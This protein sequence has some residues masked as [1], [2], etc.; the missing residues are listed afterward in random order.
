MPRA[1]IHQRLNHANARAQQAP[2]SRIELSSESRLAAYLLE[3]YFWGQQ[4]LPQIQKTA[5]LA[6]DDMQACGCIPPANLTVLAN[7]GQRGQRPNNMRR[8][9]TSWLGSPRLPMPSLVSLPVASLSV[10]GWML[11]HLGV[12]WPHEMF[13]ALYHQ[14]PEVFRQNLLGGSPDNV[15]RFWKHMERH[16]AM[17]SNP[18]HALPA[19]PQKAIPLCLAGDG[20]PVLSIGKSWQ[21][22]ADVWFWYSLLNTG[23]SISGFWLITCLWSM[24]MCETFLCSTKTKFMKKL[25]WSLMSLYQGCWP[26][27]DEEGRATLDSRSGFLADG[28]CGV[29]FLTSG[30]LEWYY[31]WLQL[32]HFA[33]NFPC[34][35]CSAHKS[36]TL[37][38]RPTANWRK[39]IW[40]ARAW[41]AANP[42]RIWLFKL[43]GF[44]SLNVVRDYMHNKHLGADRYFYGST[45]FL[46]I[47]ELMRGT[48]DENCARLVHEIK[49]NATATSFNR[50][51]PTMI[52]KKPD[53]EAELKGRA[54][55]IKHCSHGLLHVWTKFMDKACVQHVQIK[56][57]LEAS[58]EMDQILDAGSKQCQLSAAEA[59]KFATTVDRYAVLCNAL[60]IHYGDQRLFNVTHKLHLLQEAGFHASY[61]NPAFASAW[62]AEDFVAKLKEILLACV[63]GSPADLAQRKALE[64]YLFAMDWH[65]KSGRSVVRRR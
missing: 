50:L 14:Y 10:R 55:E 65:C 58:I 8:D 40:T 49:A 59:K 37:D 28:W 36:D 1:G 44:S 26:A 7:L 29:L 53:Q 2:S 34:F 43:P 62:G 41:I 45:M 42:N 46:L 56:L 52:K 39:L 30:D 9:L 21:Q 15:P 60:R 12:L 23:F 5:A 63:K 20:V 38:F 22:S 19:F 64:R 27:V 24:Q 17:A 57:A 32:P 48:P 54:S 3:T 6:V 16:P 31:K 13:A 47:N 25:H 18:H 51:K 4:T 35:G 61:L 33:C 11:N